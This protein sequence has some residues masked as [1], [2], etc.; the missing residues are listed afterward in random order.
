M[1]GPSHDSP[2]P[3][4]VSGFSLFWTFLRIGFTTF[5]GGFAMAAVLRHELVLKRRWLTE[6]E[7]FDTLCT[8]TAIPG[9]VAVNLA[10]L[11]GRRLRGLSG[12]LT[13]AVGTVCPSVLMIL[14]IARV[15]APYFDQPTVAAFLKGCAIAVAGQIAFAAFAFVRGLRPH[16]QNAAVC[17]LGLSVLALGAHPVWAVAATAVLGY[18]IMHKRMARRTDE[19]EAELDL[20]ELIEGITAP[21][22]A[23]GSFEKDLKDV[24]HKSDE[25]MWARFATLLEE[26]PVLDLRESM[27]VDEFLDLA[28]EELAPRLHADATTLASALKN[29]EAKSSTVLNQWLAVPHVILEGEGTFEMLMARSRGGVRFSG[30]AQDIRTVFVLV[31]SVDE[32][33]FYLRA[34]VRIARIAGNDE[35]RERWL[36]AEG[37]R[38]LKEAARLAGRTATG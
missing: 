12:G 32:R 28:A 29:R 14:L 25:T 3:R 10:F 9:A 1:N 5:G 7:F 31:G 19:A 24:L 15:A 13:A 22:F 27:S 33:D 23:T 30:Q 26:C 16:W 36:E 17:G 18:L 2:E 20:L 21:E 6:R 34:L 35:F 4:R 11:E 38:G 8:A 37:T